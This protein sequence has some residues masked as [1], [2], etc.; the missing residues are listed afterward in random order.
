MGSGIP[1]R[2]ARPLPTQARAVQTR[3]LT[4]ETSSRSQ[5]GRVDKLFPRPDR[6]V[7]VSV[8]PADSSR[9]F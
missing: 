4:A 5:L 9:R 8:L 6:N 2:Y 7:L 1:A 3:E